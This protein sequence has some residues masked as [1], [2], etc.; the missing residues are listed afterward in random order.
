MHVQ[1][2]RNATLRVEYAGKPFLI[3]PFLGEKGAYPPLPNSE[4]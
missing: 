4:R 1:L 2:I 3:D